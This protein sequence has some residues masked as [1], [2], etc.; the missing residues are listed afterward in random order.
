MVDLLKGAVGQAPTFGE[1]AKLKAQYAGEQ[2]QDA[3]GQATDSASSVLSDAYEYATNS[4]AS[5]ASVA[6]KTISSAALE[7]SKSAASAWEVAG[8]SYS[9]A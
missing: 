4:G 9:S 7:A 5:A 2:G 6:S 1:E 3:Y 8:V